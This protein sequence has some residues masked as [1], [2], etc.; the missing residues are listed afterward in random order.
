MLKVHLYGLVYL[1]GPLR[2][3]G[4]LTCVEAFRFCEALLHQYRTFSLPYG[5]LSPS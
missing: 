1:C 2:L 5:A 3:H 4:P